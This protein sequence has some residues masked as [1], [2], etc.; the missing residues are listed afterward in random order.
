MRSVERR[1]CSLC[2]LLKEVF[3]SVWPMG[4]QHHHSLELATAIAFFPKAQT[5][6]CAVRGSGFNLFSM[7]ILAGKHSQHC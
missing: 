3:H 2:V 4:N 7:L 5:S 1:S 6:D